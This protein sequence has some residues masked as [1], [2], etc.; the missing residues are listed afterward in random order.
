MYERIY[1]LIFLEEKKTV[2]ERGERDIF[3]VFNQN[4][5]E[6]FSKGTIIP[7]QINNVVVRKLCTKLGVSSMSIQLELCFYHSRKF[8]K[9]III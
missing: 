5:I 3:F 9:K 4:P 7:H 6:Y 1:L 2:E 8:N